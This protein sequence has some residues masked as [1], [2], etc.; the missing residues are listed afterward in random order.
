MNEWIVSLQTVLLTHA[1][2][3][4]YRL[5]GAIALWIV[6]TFAIR[7]IRRLTHAALERRK[8]DPMLARYTESTLNVLL[9][10][11]LLLTI[12]SVVG[13]ETTSFAA[14]LAA[15]GIAIG[16]AWAGLLSNFAA[17]V[18]LLTL[19]PFKVGDDIVAGGT[20]GTVQEVGLFVT[21]LHTGAN[22]RVFIGNSRL[23]SETLQNLSVNP[24]VR[25][26]IKVVLP[27][28]VNPREAIR[29]LNERVRKIQGV[30]DAPAPEIGIVEF[31]PL[32]PLLAVRPFCANVD[33]GAVFF[34][35]NLVIHEVFAAAGY[36]PP[37]QHHVIRAAA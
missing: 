18:F 6:G 13:V 9:K 12:F 31:T 21:T 26:E 30:H 19:R 27:H 4:V 1:V 11:L 37:Q 17:G 25:T 10:L 5:I 16:A 23:L 20:A 7:A 35:T 3:V 2:P 28:G 34:E 36:P 29:E 8:L 33:Q 24:V 32:G 15:A 14:V 22:V